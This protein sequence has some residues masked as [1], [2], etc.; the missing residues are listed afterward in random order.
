MKTIKIKQVIRY[1]IYLK[2]K[3]NNMYDKMILCHKTNYY[4]A[5]LSTE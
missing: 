5:L 2:I 1:V 3:P 4:R